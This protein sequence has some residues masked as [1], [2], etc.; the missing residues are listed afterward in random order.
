MPDLEYFDIDNMNEED[1]EHCASWHHDESVR[2]KS[3][4]DTYHLLKEMLK[5]CY[6]DCFVLSTAFTRFNE[7]MIGELKQTSICG[8]LRH[9][10]TILVYFITLP[11]MVIHWYIGCM[12]PEHCLAIVPNRGY[13][14]GKCGSVKENVWLAYLDKLHE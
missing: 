6:D 7:S 10:F 14:S 3:Q 9:E 1:R 12:M 11:Q 13:D 8:I 4:D 5:Y 2:I